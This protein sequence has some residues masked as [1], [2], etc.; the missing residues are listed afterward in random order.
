M[1]IFS[2]ISCVWFFSGLINYLVCFYESHQWAKNNPETGEEIY[3]NVH[4]G[5]SYIT[6]FIIAILLGPVGL[7]FLLIDYFNKHKEKTR[8]PENGE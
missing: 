7:T 2:I 4:D 6:G 8:E 3:E 1:K 5:S